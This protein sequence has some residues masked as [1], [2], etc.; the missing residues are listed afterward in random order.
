V[1]DRR[2]GRRAALRKQFRVAQDHHPRR[3]RL[4]RELG[5]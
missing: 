5:A 2:D 1:L 4:P 3:Q